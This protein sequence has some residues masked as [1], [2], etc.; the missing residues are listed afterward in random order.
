MGNKFWGGIA[1]LAAVVAGAG[2]AGAADMAPVYKAPPPVILSDWAGFYIGVHGGYG[3]G[4]STFPAEFCPVV[5]VAEADVI[6]QCP[7]KDI[8]P[9]QK[10]GLFGGHAG[11]NW[12]YGQI[13]TG[14]EVDFD[15]A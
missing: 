1:T 8:A 15:G 6:Q 11:Y 3:W 7:V 12:Q 10:G 9:R 14:L 2:A 13:V 5:R 4:H